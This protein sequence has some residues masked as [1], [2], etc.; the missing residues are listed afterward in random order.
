MKRILESEASKGLTEVFT[1]GKEEEHKRGRQ[2]LCQWTQPSV[3][4]LRMK[5]SS[6]IWGKEQLRASDKGKITPPSPRAPHTIQKRMQFLWQAGFISLGLVFGYLTTTAVRK[7]VYILL[8]LLPW[9]W[10]Y[11]EKYPRSNLHRDGHI[12]LWSG[13]RMSKT[14]RCAQGKGC[15]RSRHG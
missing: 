11:R 2:V 10:L 3:L 15:I 4:A 7:S 1:V 8:P 13:E 12:W 5:K 6:Q 9:W 14:L